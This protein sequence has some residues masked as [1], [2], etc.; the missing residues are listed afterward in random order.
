[1]MDPLPNQLSDRGKELQATQ[2]AAEWLHNSS[3]SKQDFRIISNKS[4]RKHL[5]SAAVR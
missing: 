3:N 2:A 5:K 1:M 4:K